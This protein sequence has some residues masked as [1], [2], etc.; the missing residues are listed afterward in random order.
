M[1]E[2][3][4]KSGQG[5]SLPRES[6]GVQACHI[7][8]PKEALL[9][10]V[11]ALP[12]PWQK[13]WATAPSAADHGLQPLLIRKSSQENSELPKVGP[14][15]LVY[16]GARDLAPRPPSWQEGLA[17]TPGAVWP[18]NSWAK[19]W[20]GRTTAPR[21][22]PVARSG[23]GLWGV[24]WLESRKEQWWLLSCFSCCTQPRKVICSSLVAD[25]SLQATHTGSLTRAQRKMHSSSHG[26][27]YTVTWIEQSSGLS[28][29]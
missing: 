22:N 6:G 27:I 11:P 1:G 17:R 7:G 25:C 8:V 18:C 12:R 5:R 2:P 13:S 29:L 26:P 9:A 16:M 4:C 23:Q 10:L 20:V 28:S 19:K 24:G 15:S 21:A 14:S 3:I